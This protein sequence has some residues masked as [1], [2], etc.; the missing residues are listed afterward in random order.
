MHASL[1]LKIAKKKDVATK[2]RHDDKR[3]YVTRA[4]KKE[5]E[6]EK[7]KEKKKID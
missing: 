2:S 3:H 7:E 6:K 1:R 5:K 4:C